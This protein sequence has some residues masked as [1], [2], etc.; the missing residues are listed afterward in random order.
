MEKQNQ[1]DIQELIE[2]ISQKNYLKVKD[3]FVDI[4]PADIAEIVE[5]LNLEEQV[6]IISVLDNDISASVLLELDEDTR[7]EILEQFTS[8]EIAEEVIDEIDSDDAA[9]LIAELTHDKKVEVISQ[10]EDE[11]HAK[12]IVDLLKYDEDSAGGLMAKELVK[13][14]KNWSIIQAVR[15]MRRQAEEMDEVFSI[16]VV[17]DKER[18]IGLLSLKKLLTTSA[19]AKVE[20]IYKPNVHSVKADEDLEIVG[21]LM[22]K[23]DLVELPVTDEL[24]VLIGRITI[25]DI[26]DVIKEEAEKDYQLASGISSDVDSQDKIIDIL[27]ARLP[28]LFIGMIGG[29]LGSVV[30]RSNQGFSSQFPLLLAFIP[31]IAATAGNV[32]VQASAIVVQGL[33]NGTLKKSISKNL[34]K[35]VAVAL[36]TGLALSMIIFLYNFIVNDQYLVSFTISLSLLVIIIFSASVGTLIPLLLNKYNI[37]PAVATGP[38]ITTS[39][40]VLGILIYFLIAKSILGF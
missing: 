18:L 22:R 34:F 8:K 23:Y 21:N 40:D 39:N 5:N 29:L 9:D 20:D 35:E 32:G 30:I 19:N 2:F 26:M 4:H 6:F 10:L 12:S 31:L 28:W 14:N 17:D 27:K 7:K 38:F 15:E 1:I 24:N 25:D 13:V 37:D 33:A 11:E 36:F 16:Y 3:F